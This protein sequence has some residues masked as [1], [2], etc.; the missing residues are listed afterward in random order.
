MKPLK[1]ALDFFTGRRNLIK[2]NVGG[3]GMYLIE[4]MPSIKSRKARTF[5]HHSIICCIT[6]A[7][8]Y[9]LNIDTM[10]NV[11]YKNIDKMTGDAGERFIKW[12]TVYHTLFFTNEIRGSEEVPDFEEALYAIFDFDDAEK[13]KYGEFKRLLYEN[14]AEFIVAFSNTAVK[15]IFNVEEISSLD[16][17]FIYNFYYNCYN[18]F[19]RSYTKYTLMS[20]TPVKPLKESDSPCVEIGQVSN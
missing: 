12:E 13:E 5:F 4:K 20:F 16:T 6:D 19:Y 1:S 8:E 9:F 15:D 11:F 10:N 14:E 7:F 18:E 3:S 17:S 2:D